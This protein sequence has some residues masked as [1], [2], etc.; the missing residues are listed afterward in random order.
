MTHV[1]ERRDI[2][3]EIEFHLQET[4]DALVAEGMTPDA[5]RAEA[6]RRYGNRRRHAAN[7]RRSHDDDART[8]W[9]LMTLA[10]AVWQEVR[11]AARALRRSPSYT[12]TA[13][14]TLALVSGVNLTMFGIADG[15]TYRPLAWLK[16]AGDVHRVYWQWTA[17]GR[18]TTSASTQYPRLMDL[19]KETRAFADVAAFAERSVRVGDGADAQQHPIAAISASYFRFFDATPALGR[20]FTEAEDTVPKGA[21]VAVLGYRYWQSRFG[22]RDVLGQVIAIADMRATII[23]VAP[24]GFDG[25]NDGRPP[26]AFV[27]ITS[28]A[29]STGTTDAQTYFSSYNWGWVHLL[30]RRASNVNHETAEAEATRVFQTTS[31]RIA[32]E[33]PNQAAGDITQRRVILSALRPGAGP[34]AGPEAKTAS[35]LLLVATAVLIIGCANV[36]NLSVIRGLARRQEVGVKRALGISQFRVVCAAFAEAAL[37]AATAGIVALVLAQTLRTALSPVLTSLRIAEISVLADP[38][39]LAVT[40]I[41][42]A[43]GTL[44]IGAVPVWLLSRRDFGAALRP[45][46][47]TTTEGRRVRGALL[48]AQSMLSVTLLVGA[49]L[50]VRSLLAAYQAPLGYDPTGVLLVTRVI[51]AGGFDP[52]RNIAL[53]H[54]LL[55]AAQAM[56][57]VETAAWM[58]SAPFVSTSSTDIHVAGLD[59]ATNLGP[60]TFQATTA[61]YFKTMRTRV[62]RGRGL[63]PTDTMGAPEVVVISESMARVLWPGQEALGQCFRMREL[64]SPCRTVV[65]IAEDIV[66]REIADGPRLHYYVPIDQYPRTFGNG[67]IVRLRGGSREAA[68]R[69]RTDLQSGMP[70]GS[71]LVVQRLEDIVG[72]QRGSWRLGAVVLVGFGVVA[73]A[74]AGVGLFG[75]MSY[76]IAQRSREWA[77]RSALGADRAWIVRAVVGRSLVVACLG[78]IPGLAIAAAAGGTIQ[79]MLYRTSALDPWSFAAAALLMLAAA[80]AAS[81]GPALAASRVSPSTALK[82][83]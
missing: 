9:S 31:L 78:I 46:R 57:D 65:G 72:D 29:A 53:R 8:P 49:G 79:P 38:R 66:Q 33:N 28:Y 17:N 15:L 20:F 6:E 59:N 26:A 21:D 39:T 54:D 11:L 75:A 40:A 55:T 60:F 76:D 67:L 3:D 74:V 1:P 12:L 81:A 18:L 80:C 58:S 13:I 56:P 16:D 7:M 43:A 48:V 25:L 4:V 30:V 23:G 36:A 68:E 47:G 73:L 45:T 63:L 71:H 52:A 51:P 27:P 77:I 32:A 14:L 61:D 83:E 19:S 24:P 35:W 34:T 64:T 22:G 62:L 50:F 10:A 2:D 70:A 41:I 82:G 69:I 37:I 42:M 5:A 44:I